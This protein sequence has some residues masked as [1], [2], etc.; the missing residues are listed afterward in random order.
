M[1]WQEILGL[2][3]HDFSMNPKRE[4]GPPDDDIRIIRLPHVENINMQFQNCIVGKPLQDDKP[5]SFLTKVVK[6][7][8]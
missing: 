6:S 7:V 1:Y 4:I 2:K 3:K 8:V 5:R